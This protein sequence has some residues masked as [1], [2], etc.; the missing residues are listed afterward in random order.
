MLRPLPKALWPRSYP[1]YAL[2][3]LTL[4]LALGGMAF[5]CQA[6]S[7]QPLQKFYLSTY[8]RTQ[9]LPGRQNFQMVEAYSLK[10]RRMVVVMA[11]DPWVRIEGASKQKRFYATK[12]G[13]AA[14]INS[15]FLAWLRKADPDK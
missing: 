8:L 11:T 1:L 13:I 7:L 12:E 10:D 9:I 15:P 5:W 3:G 2:I 6:A 4:G 14:G